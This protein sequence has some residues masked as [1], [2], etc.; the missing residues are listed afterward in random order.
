MELHNIGVS[1]LVEMI[2]SDNGDD[3]CVCER[4][5]PFFTFTFS[6]KGTAD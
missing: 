3:V 6:L 2:L 5:M 1:I 4:E